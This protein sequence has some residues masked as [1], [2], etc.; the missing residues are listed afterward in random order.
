M[1]MRS[2]H[3]PLLQVGLAYI[4]RTRVTKFKLNLF[5][6]ALAA[7]AL[8]SP[9]AANASAEQVE[10]SLRTSASFV[11]SELLVQFR[12]GVSAATRS[13]AL[14]AVGG[15][16]LEK[17]RA[18]RG[19]TGD[20]QRVR[21]PQGASVAAA[22]RVL[23]T[24]AGVEFA[25]P[26]WVYTTQSV[27]ADPYYTSGNTW[28]VYGANTPLFTNQYGSGA[29]A[30]WNRGNTCLSKIFVGILDEGVM[31]T[32]KDLQ[33][34]VWVNPYDAAEGTDEDGNGYVDDINGWDFLNNDNSVFD[35][36]GDEHGTQVAGIIGAQ[37][38]DKGM[39]GVCWVTN[40]VVAK[41]MDSGKGN[42]A[43][44][45]KALDYLIDLKARHGLK[46]TAVNASWGGEGYSDT[47]KAAIQRAADADILFVTAS[48]NGGGN[49]DKTPFYPAS[50][51]LPNMIT[52]AAITNTG[53]LAGYSNWGPGTVDIGAPGAGIYTTNPV[54]KSGEFKSGYA[55][56]SGTSWAA[57][58]VTGAA[59]LYASSHPNSSAAAIK[60]A[61]ITSAL[62][63]TS[64]NGKVATGARLDASGF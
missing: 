60:S 35:G 32:H 61:I 7:M 47:L 31:T 5:G 55:S 48:G 17:L 37:G 3:K 39:A 50:Y 38:N 57:A 46:V 58:F 41:I 19:E 52:V 51:K 34:N 8:A 59:A 42:A 9:L 62:P 64:L 16:M 20:L 44:A 33:K 30:A 36:L 54:F 56:L 12:G 23:R 53:G 29:A 2:S 1:F 11:P 27:S 63:T 26:N 40:M 18:A 21:L 4:R 6:A 45:I 22:A 10:A 15:R 28:G 49:I 25:E 43:N 14:S 24:H 13:A